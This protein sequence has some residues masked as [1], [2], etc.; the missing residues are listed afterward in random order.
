[1]E[2]K[3]NNKHSC[4]HPNIDT[5]FHDIYKSEF[6]EYRSLSGDDHDAEN[7]IENSKASAED[8]N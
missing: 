2:P 3:C 6:G 1:M 5:A 4:R 7:Y 8:L